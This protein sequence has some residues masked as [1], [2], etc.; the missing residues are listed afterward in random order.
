ML[1]RAARH[2][3]SIDDGLTGLIDLLAQWGDAGALRGDAKLLREAVLREAANAD[4]LP[5]KVP[6]GKSAEALT[7]EPQ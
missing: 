5:E 4:K 7:P 2:Q 1:H 6:A 3:K